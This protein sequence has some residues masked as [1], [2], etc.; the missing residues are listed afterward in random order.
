M[1]T[2]I[3]KEING[4]FHKTNINARF[5]L[6]NEIFNIGKYFSHK[7]KQLLLRRSNVVYKINCSCGD[8]YIGQTKRNLINRLNEHNPKFSKQETDV[9]KHLIENSN[10]K[11][12]TNSVKILSYANNWRKLL[13]KETLFIQKLEPNLNVDQTSTNLFLFNT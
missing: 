5:V 11:I 13:I 1:S 9:T 6:I 10:H 2:N 7:D 12:N 8:T 3:K 4:F